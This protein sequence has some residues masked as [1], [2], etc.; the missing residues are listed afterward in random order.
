MASGTAE[1]MLGLGRFSR[2]APA[3]LGPSNGQENCR[4]PFSDVDE[5]SYDIISPFGLSVA[6][7][8]DG[9]AD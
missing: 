4:A 7:H 2:H 3:A 9:K 6:L 1:R 5:P 8:R